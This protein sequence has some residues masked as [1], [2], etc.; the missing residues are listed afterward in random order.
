MFCSEYLNG[1]GQGDQVGREDRAAE[2]ST[3]D[4][5]DLVDLGLGLDFTALL[6]L[7]DPDLVSTNS[8][9]SRHENM[10]ARV[11]L[12]RHENVLLPGIEGSWLGHF[13][14]RSQF[15]IAKSRY[16]EQKTSSLARPNNQIVFFGE[17][18][19]VRIYKH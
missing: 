11:V 18:Q 16:S 4:L 9:R 10:Q 8:L 19:H 17:K 2:D 1:Q 12:P 13:L 7:E 15:C 5:G 3:E 6:V 14:K